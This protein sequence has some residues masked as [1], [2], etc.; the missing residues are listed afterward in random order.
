MLLVRH[1][2]DCPCICTPMWCAATSSLGGFLGCLCPPVLRNSPYEVSRIIFCVSNGATQ[3][4]TAERAFLSE[5]NIFAWFEVSKT[6][7]GHSSVF[8][9]KKKSEGTFLLLFFMENSNFTLTTAFQN[10]IPAY[11]YIYIGVY[12]IYKYI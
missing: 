8:E 9:V 4:L 3:D 10:N 7:R 2:L 6:L 5:T 12:Q 11:I 1:I